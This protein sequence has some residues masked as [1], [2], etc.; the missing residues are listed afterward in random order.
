MVV[1]AHGP[2]NTRQHPGFQA[3][4]RENIKLFGVFQGV[5]D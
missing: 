3:N 5:A 1:A 4:F 2:Q